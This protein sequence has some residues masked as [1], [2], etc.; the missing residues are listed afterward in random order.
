MQE[1]LPLRPAEFVKI[2]DGFIAFLKQPAGTPIEHVVPQHIIDAM[3]SAAKRGRNR[4]RMLDIVKSAST[5]VS[6]AG[7]IVGFAIEPM[8]LGVVIMIAGGS[9]LVWAINRAKVRNEPE[10]DE[11]G[12]EPNSVLQRNL[13]ALDNFRNL[14]ASGEIACEE[15][16]PDGTIKPVSSNARRAFIADHGSLLILS[17][18]QDLWQCI[19]PRPI[20]MSPLWVK[21]GNRVATT[22][23]TARTILDTSD[24]PL[25]ERRID[26]L[27]SAADQNSRLAR[28]F[29]EDVN[30]LAELRRL[31][32]QGSSLDA[33]KLA[34]AEQGYGMTRVAQMHAGIYVPF[35]KFLAKLPLDEFP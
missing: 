6:V 30:I 26:W 25:F 9:G 3:A 19:P 29:R 15:R 27:L 2:R 18:D 13:R 35:E 12:T 34:L 16:L 28:S 21:V 10:V 4:R 14:I 32:G 24:A 8:I 23:I 1:Q 11:L 33:C 5:I 17:R 7:A 20:P 31:K 22:M